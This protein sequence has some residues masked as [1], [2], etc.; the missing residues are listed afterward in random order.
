MNAVKRIHN[1]RA[2][3]ANDGRRRRRREEHFTATA[4]SVSISSGGGGRGEG[5]GRMRWVGEGFE[6]RARPDSC[7][8]RSSVFRQDA[9]SS[10]GRDRTTCRLSLPA[11][12][13]P[14][15][16]ITNYAVTETLYR[17]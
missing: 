6:V 8:G 11:N 10:T 15:I 16:G 17:I 14:D 12:T 1:P 2:K 7:T 9:P 4:Q 5:K 3:I 13:D